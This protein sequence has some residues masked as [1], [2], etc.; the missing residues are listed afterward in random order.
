MKVKAVYHV[1][2]NGTLYGPGDEI[3][4]ADKAARHCIKSGSVIKADA[5][6][7]QGPPPGGGQGPRE[8]KPGQPFPYTEPELMD[9][10]MDELRAIGDRYNVKGT[11]KDE[12][13][14]KI[15]AAHAETMGPS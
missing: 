8:I 11:L 15:M 14:G 6:G 2:Y 9:M 4:M 1:K 5:G 3:D 13:A 10:K 12:L 7:K